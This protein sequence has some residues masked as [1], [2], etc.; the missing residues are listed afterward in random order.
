MFIRNICHCDSTNIEISLYI[1][2][3][4]YSYV[5]IVQTMKMKIY[6]TLIDILM[7][8]YKNAHHLQNKF[9]TS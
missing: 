5:Y 1:N 6:L 9:E 7:I 3:Y 4:I 2:M 8:S